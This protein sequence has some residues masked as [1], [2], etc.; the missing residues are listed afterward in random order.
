MNFTFDFVIDKKT[1]LQHIV[2]KASFRLGYM[3]MYD[4]KD[5]ATKLRV[6]LLHNDR[7]VFETNLDLPEH[8]T[9]KTANLM[10]TKAIL[11]HIA[12]TSDKDG[13]MC[14]YPYAVNSD[15]PEPKFPGSDL[16]EQNV[17]VNATAPMELL[18]AGKHL[19][20][21]DV[22]DTITVDKTTHQIDKVTYQT[23][24]VT[25]QIVRIKDIYP[26][27]RLCYCVRKN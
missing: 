2:M 1:D 15:K 6:S 12:N 5:N 27:T 11:D 17:Y 9:I 13:V 23:N 19:T 26:A 3:A 8:C 16:P 20:T 25:Y 10:A 18:Y 22:G 7:P 21:Y 14:I 4:T 24:R